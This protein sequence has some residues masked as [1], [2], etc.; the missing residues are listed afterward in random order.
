MQWTCM[1]TLKISNFAYQ[2]KINTPKNSFQK[3][4]RKFDWKPTVRDRKFGE[5]YKKLPN[6]IL[7]WLLKKSVWHTCTYTILSR[8]IATFAFRSSHWTTI[9][10][11]IRIRLFIHF[12]VAFACTSHSA[13]HPFRSTCSGFHAGIN[14]CKVN[15]HRTSLPC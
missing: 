10:N 8:V 9:L 11:S 5:K 3:I 12:A 6:N 2:K 15:L 7:G 13:S 1:R 4:I 14:T